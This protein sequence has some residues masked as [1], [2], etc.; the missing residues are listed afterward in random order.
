MMPDV[1]RE[2]YPMLAVA[3][4]IRP[5]AAGLSLFQNAPEILAG[6]AA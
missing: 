4:A 5:G 3:R 1:P 2:R 6:Q